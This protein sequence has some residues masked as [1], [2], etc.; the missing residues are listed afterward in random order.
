MLSFDWPNRDV[1]R[2]HSIWATQPDLMLGHLPICPKWPNVAHFC[3]QL[4]SFAHNLLISRTIAPTAYQFGQNLPCCPCL[5]PLS[6]GFTRSCQIARICGILQTTCANLHSL[7][8]YGS[9]CLQRYGICVFVPNVA[10]AAPAVS[11]WRQC[12]C[13]CAKT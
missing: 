13:I 2:F 3:H 7:T 5:R 10:I 9:M 6:A 8:V 11:H 4:L 1:R 12:D